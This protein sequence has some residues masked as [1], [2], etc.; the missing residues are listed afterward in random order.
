MNEPIPERRCV[1]NPLS[2]GVMPLRYGPGAFIPPFWA[3]DAFLLEDEGDFM[4]RVRA[5]RFRE[6]WNARQQNGK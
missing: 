4:E 2:T 3:L 5:W 1:L 6:F